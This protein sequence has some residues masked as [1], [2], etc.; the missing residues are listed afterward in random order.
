MQDASPVEEGVPRRWPVPAILGHQP[1]LRGWLLPVGLGK[2]RLSLGVY[3][4]GTE[5]D[6]KLSAV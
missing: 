5:E 4:L 1:L 2:Q 6:P 3:A